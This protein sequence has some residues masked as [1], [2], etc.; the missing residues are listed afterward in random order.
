MPVLRSSIRGKKSGACRPRQPPRETSTTPG[1]PVAGGRHHEAFA[2]VGVAADLVG[3]CV[4]GVVL[5][6][7]QPKLNPI[8]TFP[9]DQPEQPVCPAGP[10]DLLV[11]RV[12]ADEAQVGEHQP[13]ERRDTERDPRVA[14]EK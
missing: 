2:D 4:M 1:S 12:M 14:H 5:G 10:K 6:D 11:P 13:E 3:M 9:D 7:H 8:N